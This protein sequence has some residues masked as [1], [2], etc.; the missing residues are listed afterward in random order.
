M[1]LILC[2]VCA[3]V[4]V[5]RLCVRVCMCVYDLLVLEPTVKGRQIST[6]H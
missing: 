6:C 1:E 5:L 3:Y 2:C 4:R